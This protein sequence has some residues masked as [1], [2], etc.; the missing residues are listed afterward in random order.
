MRKQLRFA[1]VEKIWLSDGRY[2]DLLSGSRDEPEM[3]DTFPVL[4][5]VYNDFYRVK[6]AKDI[7]SDLT[8]SAFCSKCEKDQRLCEKTEIKLPTCE[9]HQIL[10]APIDECECPFWKCD[11]RWPNMTT[12][13]HTIKKKNNYTVHVCPP[14]NSNIKCCKK[15]RLVN[16]QCMCQKF[17]CEKKAE[18]CLEE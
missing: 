16:N 8:E 3:K 12:C 5:K 14:P 18:S 15:K 2:L 11:D 10:M 4:C 17:I 1:H 9:K 13:S 6:C 7:Y